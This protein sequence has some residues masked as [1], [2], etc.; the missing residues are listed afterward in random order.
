MENLWIWT[1]KKPPVTNSHNSWK[2]ILFLLLLLYSIAYFFPL[3]FLGV[4]YTFVTFNI[5]PFLSLTHLFH[6]FISY[7]SFFT[8]LWCFGG[9]LLYTYIFRFFLLN[10]LWY[11]KKIMYNIIYNNFSVILYFCGFFFVTFLR[12]N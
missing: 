6:H 12:K 1:E 4:A 5:I 8:L 2:I 3:V 11:R 9:G 7:F 10:C